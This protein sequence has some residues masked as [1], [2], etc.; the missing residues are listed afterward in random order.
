MKI[1]QRS[2]Q[3]LTVSKPELKSKGD[4]AR[5]RNVNVKNADRHSPRLNIWPDIYGRTRRSGHSNVNYAKRLIV[6]SRSFV[7]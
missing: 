3:S 7:Q 5:S 1:A 6:D 2:C 4:D